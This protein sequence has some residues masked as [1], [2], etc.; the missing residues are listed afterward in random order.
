LQSSHIKAEQEILEK[1][2]K[3][4]VATPHGMLHVLLCHDNCR[5]VQSLSRRYATSTTQYHILPICY[6]TVSDL[7]QNLP[8]PIGDLHPIETRSSADAEGPGNMPQIQNIAREK[9]C[10]GKW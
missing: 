10:N 4:H 5:W 1:F 8:L 9:A 3:S 7:P 2:G 6:I